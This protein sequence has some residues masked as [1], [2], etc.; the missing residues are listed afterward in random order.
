[1]AKSF[2]LGGGLQFEQIDL[3]QAGNAALSAKQYIAKQVELGLIPKA[4]FLMFER[5]AQTVEARIRQK[6]Q[7]AYVLPKIMQ[8]SPVSY[9]EP[10]RIWHKEKEV[11]DPQLDMDM[12]GRLQD[13][14]DLEE[15]QTRLYGLTYKFGVSWREGGIMRATGRP[16][17]AI[18]SRRMIGRM[19]R[20][21]NQINIQGAKGGKVTGLLSE[22]DAATTVPATAVWSNQSTAKPF[23]DINNAIAAV[24]AED[25][26][27]PAWKIL[28]HPTNWAETARVRSSSNVIDQDLLRKMTLE[29]DSPI[30][31]VRSTA[32]PE[33]TVLGISQD[34]EQ[35]DLLTTGLP[36]LVPVKA[37]AEHAEWALRMIAIERVTEKKALFKLTGV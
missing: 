16:M 3:Q 30:Q 7:Q 21:A 31:F 25:I 20:A 33:G 4:N 18:T 26:E 11:R 32:I 24:G 14:G 35:V 2:D 28:V 8:P 29:A 15:F 13:E 19:L 36:Q 10:V 12:I 1:M 6:A 17:E 27:V 5:Q 22:V 9:F 37:D 34:E 23:E